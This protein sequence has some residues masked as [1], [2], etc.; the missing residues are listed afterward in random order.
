MLQP[1][2]LDSMAWIQKSRMADV[3]HLGVVSQCK[4]SCIWGTQKQAAMSSIL[5]SFRAKCYF[6][7]ILSKYDLEVRRVCRHFQFLPLLV[8]VGLC[9]LSLP[10]CPPACVP[11]STPVQSIHA[12]MCVPGRLSASACPAARAGEQSMPFLST[13][14]LCDLLGSPD[15][16]PFM[17]WGFGPH[18]S[19]M[20]LHVAPV[21][22]L[23]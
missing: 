12:S 20:E 22:P 14:I 1:V 13:H 19:F 10:V 9:C 21:A 17:M 7:T 6:C 23:V 4:L 2:C 11:V 16:L 18:S 5:N 3:R 15:P 8:S